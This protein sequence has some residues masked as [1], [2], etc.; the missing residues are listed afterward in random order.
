MVLMRGSAIWSMICFVLQVQPHSRHSTMSEHRA[1]S[2]KV[3]VAVQQ[4]H[5]LFL[6]A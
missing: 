2:K 5:F 4:I 6:W 3:Q 1:V